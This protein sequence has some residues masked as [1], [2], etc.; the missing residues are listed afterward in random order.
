MKLDFK[1]LKEQILSPGNIFWQQKSGTVVLLSSKAD[2]L[3]YDLIQKLNNSHHELLIEDQIDFQLQDEFVELFKA[4]DE[5]LLVKEKKEWRSR[6][7]D[8]C[9]NKFSQK[10]FP[11]WEMD[12]MVWR[13]FST[14]TKEETK[15]YIDLDLDLFKRSL[16]VASS[17]VLCAFLLGYYS[18]VYLKKLFAD[19][20]RSLMSMDEV[21]SLITLKN[22]LE[23][24]RTLDTLANDERTFLQGVYHASTSLVGERYDGSGIKNI[25]KRE[26]N[27]V[28]IVLVALCAYYPYGKKNEQNIFYALKNSQ[29]KCERKILNVLRRS[30]EK[31]EATASM[32]A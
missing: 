10:D 29:L 18:D 3:N 27:D 16:S 2:F 1:N 13:V 28:E 15:N 19:T 23:E 6:I 7:L 22:K 9:I 31:P 32:S 20:F 12:Q 21:E 25:H 24:I 17:T 5:V 8:L 26:M 11:Q 4:H 14:L 30:L